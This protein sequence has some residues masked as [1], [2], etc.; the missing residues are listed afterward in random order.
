MNIKLSGG[1]KIIEPFTTE[2]SKPYLAQ[3]LSG[4]TSYYP[5]ET[6]TSGEGV[7]IKGNNETYIVSEEN[8]PVSLR[9][10]ISSDRLLQVKMYDSNNVLQ[11]T[12]N[13]P[14]TME[15]DVFPGG[16]VELIHDSKVGW[17]YLDIDHW[18]IWDATYL[19][20]GQPHSSCFINVP[21]ISRASRTA[22]LLFNQF[23][24]TGSDDYLNYHISDTKGW[25]RSEYCYPYI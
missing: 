8:P 15:M 4:G 14:G 18:D 1:T 24:S 7:L 10:A 23:S 17:V 2:P 9:M 13:A 21:L 12:Y 6:Y 5:L 20:H 25:I 11:R 3:K 16:K 22:T 19:D